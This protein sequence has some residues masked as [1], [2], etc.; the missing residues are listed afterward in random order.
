MEKK[1]ELTILLPIY[2]PPDGWVDILKNSLD[3]L[4]PLFEGTLLELLL[5]NDG[6]TRNLEAG[7]AELSK[8]HEC[9]RY[10]SYDHNQ[11]KGFAIRTGLKEAD[12]E[13]YMYT[14]WD[15]PFGEE[16]VYQAYRLLKQNNADLLIGVRSQNYFASLPLSR[17]ILSQGLRV[18]NFFVLNFNYVDTQA[19]IKG[20][21]NAA[22]AVF[23]T[24]KTNSFIFELEFVR[25][26]FRRKLNISY[27]S[28][29]P[30]QDITFSNFG[31]KTVSREMAVFM[32][33]A[34]T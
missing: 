24:N 8:A 7:I 25:D 16:S 32:K 10:V 5:I 29:N 31:L 12:S 4:F 11:G 3:K 1:T 21:S 15:F 27:L 26:C 14:D 20:L 2:N 22:R 6:S 9:I 23:L 28:V 19:G 17:K 18:L 33:I 34:F 30:K 13:F